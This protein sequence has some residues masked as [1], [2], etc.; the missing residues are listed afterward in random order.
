MAENASSEPFVLPYNVKVADLNQVA[1]LLRTRATGATDS[2]VRRAIGASLCDQ[3]KIAFYE[4]TQFIAVDNGRW[5]LTSQGSDYVHG[6]EARKQKRLRD[7]LRSHVAYRDV[8]SWAFYDQK[9]SLSA[10]EVR[11]KWVNEFAGIV[12]QENK[13][14]INGAPVTFFDLC[15]HAGL[16]KFV[17]GRRGAPSRLEID[18]TTLRSFTESDQSLSSE[19]P[20]TAASLGN[21]ILARPEPV[22]LRVG[23]PRDQE[24]P[25][26]L[27][28][29]RLIAV[30][31]PDEIPAEDED[32]VKAWF[33][34]MLRRRIKRQET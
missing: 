34:L 15:E 19:R 10:D 31:L 13:Y 3:R 29:H 23:G 27:S 22:Q 9:D 7:V 26:P 5:R 25:F 11:H 30:I 12:S 32:D 14:R 24:I 6:D 21:N 18:R 28:N 4:L 17:V 20:A 2:E 8:L 16:G 33:D 1:D